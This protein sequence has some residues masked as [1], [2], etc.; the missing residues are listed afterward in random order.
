MGGGGWGHGRGW[1]NIEDIEDIAGDAAPAVTP[2]QPGD[3]EDIDDIEDT[4]GER[5]GDID[6][7]KKEEDNLLALLS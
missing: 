6:N 1:G 2:T 3:I 5:S 7:K 4:E